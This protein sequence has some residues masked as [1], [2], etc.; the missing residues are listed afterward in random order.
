MDVELGK[1][2]RG[3]DRNRVA[4]LVNKAYY[5]GRRKAARDIKALQ[6]QNQDPN[7][8]IDTDVTEKAALFLSR[9]RGFMTGGSK[10]TLRKETKLKPIWSALLEG[11]AVTVAERLDVAT[12]KKGSPKT[13]RGSGLKPAAVL[14]ASRRPTDGSSCTSGR[15]TRR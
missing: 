14:A 2:K 10:S 6:E 13:W 15:T 5:A 12:F 4:S 7:Q 3:W 8:T 1:S 9:M 11:R